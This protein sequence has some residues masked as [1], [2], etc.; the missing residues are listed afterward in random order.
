[1]ALSQSF[2]YVCK[3]GGETD[4]VNID[5]I[6]T[7]TF[8]STDMVIGG[9]AKSITLSSINLL[10]FSDISIPVPI[11]SEHSANEP[12]TIK[13]TVTPN[14]FNPVAH[15]KIVLLQPGHISASVISTRGEIV[16]ELINQRMET[17][18]HDINWDGKTAGGVSSASGTYLFR[19][20]SE[21]KTIY[22][23]AILIR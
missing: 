4:S 8:T 23:R 15:I 9:V 13:A 17:G 3:T 6:T 22:R 18:Q 11:K 5:S 1:M 10:L 7:I 16:R 19:I 2:L 14:P 21:G 12:S 20:A